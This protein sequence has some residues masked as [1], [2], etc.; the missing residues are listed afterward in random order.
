MEINKI[1]N[2][3]KFSQDSGLSYKI[4]NE[5]VF[6]ICTAQPEKFN[7]REFA[8]FI[9]EKSRKCLSIRRDEKFKI[10]RVILSR[11]ESIK[12][13]IEINGKTEMR[14]F[15][16]TAGFAMNFEDESENRC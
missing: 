9:F 16:K 10:I 4:N 5:I 1:Q 6:D 3:T 15:V 8:K 7:I 11:D 14:N 12:V 2:I 13:E